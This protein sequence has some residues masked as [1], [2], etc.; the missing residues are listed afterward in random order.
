MFEACQT[1]RLFDG[2]RGYRSVAI[3]EKGGERAPCLLTA[4]WGVPS[5]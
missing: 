1:A 3:A 5:L 2:Q 4:C